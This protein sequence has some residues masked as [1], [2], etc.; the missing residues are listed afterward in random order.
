MKAYLHLAASGLTLTELSLRAYDGDS[1]ISLPG[2]TLTPL[3]SLNT[4]YV[5]DGL[6]DLAN[7]T[8]TFET[9][10]GVYHAR[11]FNLVLSQPQ[12]VIIP[13]REIF[14]DPITSLSI[15]L[16]IDGI[17]DSSI[18]QTTR[19]AIDGEYSVSGWDFT[20]INERWALV[21]KYN[22]IVYAHQWTGTIAVNGT[23][24][25]EI[26]A[27][28]APFPYRI[29]ADNRQLFSTNFIVRILAPTSHFEEEIEEILKAG[30]GTPPIPSSEVV[31]LGFKGVLPD[32][33]GPF[34]V[35]IP[36]GGYEPDETHDSKRENRGLQIL[37]CAEDYEACR[38]R[39]ELIFRYLD[40][41]R[42]LI[43]E[44]S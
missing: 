30:P 36:T 38:D 19:L 43:V 26:R 13:I 23:F 20:P 21:W 34:N 40:G 33:A 39:A 22:D 28:Q 5:L 25:Q 11:R 16:F 6:P 4:S 15:K 12:N 24:Y 17:E 3:V 1:L 10:I 18:L 2:A 42:N 37:T 41:L 35:I 7:L 29:S 31:Y 44:L 8:V 9:P 32:G 14:S 27:I